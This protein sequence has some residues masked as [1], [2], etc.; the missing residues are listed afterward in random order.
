MS[1]F[2]F[3]HNCSIHSMTVRLQT[4]LSHHFLIEG[5]YCMNHICY[6]YNRTLCYSKIFL[7]NRAD[8]SEALILMIC[9]SPWQSDR[10]FHIICTGTR[11]QGYLCSKCIVCDCWKSCIDL[12]RR[13]FSQ[14]YPEILTCNSENRQ[15]HF[16]LLCQVRSSVST[17][18]IVFVH[19][20][21]FPQVFQYIR[22]PFS[23][24]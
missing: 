7:P 14:I 24:D 11:I 21:T 17:T 23:R 13:A 16:H 3:Q 22:D 15:F 4:T 19:T 6:S 2:S 8:W 1:Q 18:N 9:W 5:E 10:H 12:K 20:K